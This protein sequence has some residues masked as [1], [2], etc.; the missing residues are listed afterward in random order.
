MSLEHFEA[1]G[2]AFPAQQLAATVLLMAF[3]SDNIEICTKEQGERRKKHD[4]FSRYPYSVPLLF[5][6]HWEA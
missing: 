1:L 5:P 4:L 6:C 3:H 2:T